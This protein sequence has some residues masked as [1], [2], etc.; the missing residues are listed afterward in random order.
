MPLRAQ[1]HETL[2]TYGKP[3]SQIFLHT[4][5]HTYTTLIHMH[6]HTWPT[7]APRLLTFLLM[8]LNTVRVITRRCRFLE[9][10]NADA[11]SVPESVYVNVCV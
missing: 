10:Q 3:L 7:E 5:M 2:L 8:P 4:N 1:P 6:R 11:G 9:S